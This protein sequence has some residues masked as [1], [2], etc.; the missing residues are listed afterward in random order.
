MIGSAIP[1]FDLFVMYRIQK[2]RLGIIVFASQFVIWSISLHSGVTTGIDSI[3]GLLVGVGYAIVVYVWSK[4]W[5][6]QFKEI[7]ET[8]NE[9]L[10][11]RRGKTLLSI[12]GGMFFLVFVLFS[13]H[14][15]LFMD[16]W[17]EL[18]LQE[19]QEGAKNA[20]FSE[21]PYLIWIDLALVLSIVLA[22]IFAVVGGI[23]W[24]KERKQEMK[25]TL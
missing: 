15:V 21:V 7:I 22:P 8:K 24:F 17:D 1:G 16:T 18:N 23:F 9:K 11:K 4:K 14:A 6:E 3:I 12:S 13:A 5:N 20:I 10:R 19:G 2:L 25:N